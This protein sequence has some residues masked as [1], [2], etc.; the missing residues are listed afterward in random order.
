MKY[1]FLPAAASVALCCA[2]S[3]AICALFNALVSTDTW[4]NACSAEYLEAFADR[5]ACCNCWISL[6][7]P[8]CASKFCCSNPS[9]NTCLPAKAA[10]AVADAC[11]A[12]WARVLLAKTNYLA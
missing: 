4:F 9:S 6:S 10:W 7:N 5:F 11:K 12:C 8:W 2:C 1:L 3:A